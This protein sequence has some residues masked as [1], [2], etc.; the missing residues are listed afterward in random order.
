[1]NNK[2]VTNGCTFYSTSITIL[3]VASVVFFVLITEFFLGLQIYRYIDKEI[4]GNCAEIV[5]DT[6]KTNPFGNELAA[7]TLR[8]IS[9][10][11]RVFRSKR[12]GVSKFLFVYSL[13]YTMYIYT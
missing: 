13:I 12:Q 2:F 9:R 11:L 8:R 10:D 1:M 5:S 7:E 3:K 4:R 6:L